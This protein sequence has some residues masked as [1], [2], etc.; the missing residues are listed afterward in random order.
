MSLTFPILTPI[1]D[2]YIYSFLSSLIFLLLEK[3]FFKIRPT[4]QEK[5]NVKKLRLETQKYLKEKNSKKAQETQKELAKIQ[6]K[7]MQKSFSPKILFFRMNPYSI[8][9]AFIR[10]HYKVLGVILN[11]GPIHF[12]W[13][14]TYIIFSII[15]STILNKLYTQLFEKEEV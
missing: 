1:F 5:A 15:N 6:F 13:L 10:R 12:A 14:G 9:L 8:F 11:I 7:Q 4:K 3:H 2:I